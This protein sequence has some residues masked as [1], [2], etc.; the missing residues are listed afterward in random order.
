MNDRFKDQFRIPSS[1]LPKWDYGWN[2]AYF[3]TI[4]TQKQLFFFGEIVEGKMQLSE[5]GRIAEKYWKEIPFHFSF[6]TLGD[7]VI[8]PNHVHGIIIINKVCGPVETPDPGVSSIEISDPGVSSIEISDPGVSN[9]DISD[10]GDQ[11]AIDTVLIY[12]GNMTTTGETPGSGVSTAAAA[13]KWKAGNLGVII[14]QYKRICTIKAQKIN[15][16]FAWQPRFYDH[17]IRNH[18]SFQR[19]SEYIQNNPVSWNMD[20]F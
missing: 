4:C 18:Q 19:I 14:N 16:G 5:I 11:G 9:A 12:S 15:A 3:I 20:K 6:V 2:A 17:I 13:K 1:R 10:S 7:F 8:M